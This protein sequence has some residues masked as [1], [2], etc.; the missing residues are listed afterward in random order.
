V[1]V[2]TADEPT[3]G[4]TPWLAV[5]L[6]F[7]LLS[8]ALFSYNQVVISGALRGIRARLSFSPL[9]IEVVTS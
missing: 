8:G 5:V 1:P 7:I 6:A 9:L 3:S 4:M 2:S